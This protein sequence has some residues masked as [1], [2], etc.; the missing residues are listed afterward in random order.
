LVWL[1][2]K[3]LTCGN[4]RMQVFSDCR[5]L[6]TAKGGSYEQATLEQAQMAARTQVRGT[7]ADRKALGPPATAR[8][9]P[10]V[11]VGIVEP[12][13][14]DSE[15]KLFVGDVE[16]LHDVLDKLWNNPSALG[17]TSSSATIR[18][19]GNAIYP[20]DPSKGGGGERR[21]RL[22]RR[23]EV[24][25]ST[26]TTGMSTATLVPMASRTRLTSMQWAITSL[27]A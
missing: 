13:Q 24:G 11:L 7:S 25:T 4:R 3:S 17:L 10:V 5:N 1:L 15:T 27:R 19:E 20:L 8:A 9:R 2:L 14:R 6:G 16:R 21:P 18:L 26:P 22:E 23:S 12:P